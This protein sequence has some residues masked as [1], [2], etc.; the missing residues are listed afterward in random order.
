[1]SR[2]PL[3]GEYNGKVVRV[4]SGGPRRPRDVGSVLVLEPTHD[5]ILKLS[6]LGPARAFPSILRNARYPD[7]FIERRRERQFQ[8]A[9]GLSRRSCAALCFDPDNHAPDVLA[10]YV[11]DQIRAGYAA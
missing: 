6:G 3:V 8:V 5:A 9:S 4:G 10:A 2:L 7:V 1:G 11:V